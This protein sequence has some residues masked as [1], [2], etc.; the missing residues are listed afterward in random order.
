MW[1]LGIWLRGNYDGARLIVGLD[2]LD[3]VFQP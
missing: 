2:D 3:S 1:H